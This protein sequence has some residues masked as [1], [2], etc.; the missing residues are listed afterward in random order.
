MRTGSKS[1]TGTSQQHTF[2]S[3]ASPRLCSPL[4]P[5]TDR[6]LL[7]D[8]DKKVTLLHRAFHARGLSGHPK[9]QEAGLQQVYRWVTWLPL[10]LITNC[11]RIWSDVGVIL[12]YG[13]PIIFPLLSHWSWP[14][15]VLDKCGP[16]GLVLHYL[17]FC[18]PLTITLRVRGTTST[19]EDYC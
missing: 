12:L 1:Y 6:T 2:L 14:R 9:G 10:S 19:R 15:S 4:C 7:L 5:T 17:C 13:R 18:S 8:S 3:A 16:M 11:G